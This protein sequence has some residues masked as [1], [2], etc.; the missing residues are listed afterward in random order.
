MA[1]LS[2]YLQSMGVGLLRRILCVFRVRITVFVLNK[3]AVGVRA[4]QCAGGGGAT[5]GPGRVG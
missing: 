5:P 1:V 4:T 3:E 2:A